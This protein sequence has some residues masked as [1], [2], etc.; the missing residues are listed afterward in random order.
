MPDNVTSA[1]PV[2]KSV[3]V[4]ATPQRAFELFTAHM[5]EWWPLATHSV[6]AEDAVSIL[7]GAG[8]GAEIVETMADGATSV[9]G[10]VTGWEPP[11]RVAFTWHAGTP[12]TEATRVEVTF[13]SDAPGST[14]VLLV[15][16]GWERRPDSASARDNY[17]SGWEPVVR[18]FAEAANRLAR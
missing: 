8:V 7:F 11:H 16:S 6:G 10:T 4:P 12:A 14:E 18:S 1:E 5:H 13:T 17:L 9:W 15:H 2:R 3:I